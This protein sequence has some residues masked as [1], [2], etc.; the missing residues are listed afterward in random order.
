MGVLMNIRT[1]LGE[2][3][4]TTPDPAGPSDTP[5]DPDDFTQLVGA[6]LDE[7]PL[8]YLN[9]LDHVPVLVA[10]DGMAVGA[11]G[12]YHGAGLAHPD[13]PAQIVIYRDTL[14]RDFGEDPERLAAEIRRTVR[15]ELAHHLGY[16][17]TGVRRLGL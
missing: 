1:L 14:I 5:V 13:T 6:S 16:G 17:E 9:V 4:T 2:Q 7:L 10:D 15:H 11:Y 8:E 3:P 12:L